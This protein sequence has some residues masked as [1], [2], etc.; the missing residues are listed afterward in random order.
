ALGGEVVHAH[1]LVLATLAV[2]WLNPNVYLDTVL[3]IGGI[4][5]THGDARWL[6][7]AGAITASVVWFFGLGYGARH[8]GRWLRTPRAWRILDTAIA[9]LLV[10]MGIGLVLPLFVG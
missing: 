1:Q 2:T 6:F 7:A 4:A 9:I 3:L 5:A 8:L 10:V